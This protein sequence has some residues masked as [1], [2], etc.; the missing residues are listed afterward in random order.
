MG[1]LA[2]FRRDWRKAK[3]SLRRDRE[4]RTC[5]SCGRVV[6]HQWQ[7]RFDGDGSACPRCMKGVGD[8]R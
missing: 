1:W 8:G 6:R 5:H 4:E 7:L 2:D 3:E